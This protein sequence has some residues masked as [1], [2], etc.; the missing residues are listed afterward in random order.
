MSFI[1]T[2][3]NTSFNQAIANGGVSFLVCNI[4]ILSS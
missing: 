1:A 2:K 4:I 3:E